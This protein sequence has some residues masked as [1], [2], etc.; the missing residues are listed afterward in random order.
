MD[1]RDFLVSGDVACAFEDLDTFFSW[2]SESYR[3]KLDSLVRGELSAS[4]DDVFS[5][6]MSSSIVL[7]SFFLGAGVVAGAVIF[8]G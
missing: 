5:V 6:F 1:W 3:S 4:L 2:E 7:L 8:V